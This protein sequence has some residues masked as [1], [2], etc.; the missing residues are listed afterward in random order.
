MSCKWL[1]VRVILLKTNQNKSSTIFR[2]DPGFVQ[3]FCS[4]SQS[5]SHITDYLF[6]WGEKLGYD[7]CSTQNDREMFS[8]VFRTYFSQNNLHHYPS[9]RLVFVLYSHVNC[10]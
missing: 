1:S 4:F 6:A 3:P 2:C 9:T 5:I 7:K 8:K 10:H